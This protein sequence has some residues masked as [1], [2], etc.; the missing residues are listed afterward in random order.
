MEIERENENKALT[1]E[2]SVNIRTAQQTSFLLL[3][4]ACSAA[5]LPESQSNEPAPELAA[6]DQAVVQP[7]FPAGWKYPA[8]GKADF[9]AHAMV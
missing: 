5:R 1:R 6:A 8:G 2:G 9:A 4:C 3:L 7:D